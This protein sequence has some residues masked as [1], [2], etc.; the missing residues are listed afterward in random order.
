LGKAAHGAKPSSSIPAQMTFANA[1][2]DQILGDAYGQTYK[3]GELGVFCQ[4][5]ENGNLVFHAGSRSV[6]FLFGTLYN[7]GC[8]VDPRGW[9]PA[10]PHPASLTVTGLLQMPVGSTA[11]PLAIFELDD[12]NGRLMYG[13]PG[14]CS[15]R[16]QVTRSDQQTWIIAATSTPVASG[17]GN[18]AVLEQEVSRRNKVPTSYW[19]MPFTLTVTVLQ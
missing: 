5:L 13:W 12:G 10:A 19:E 8:P 11:A 3:D 15:T 2:G 16:I 14:Y 6:N 7:T 17:A 18:V 4:L 1:P 9:I